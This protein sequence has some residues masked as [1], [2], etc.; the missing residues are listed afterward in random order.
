MTFSRKSSA[1]SISAEYA[2]I[3]EG[4]GDESRSGEGERLY[5]EDEDES[6]SGEGER[7]YAEDEDGGWLLRRRCGC[8]CGKKYGSEGAGTRRSGFNLSTKL[9]QEMPSWVN[10]GTLD[11]NTRPRG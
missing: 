6:R 3:S 2:L 8:I 4:V 11:W 1:T 5:A 9:F 7:L 10:D